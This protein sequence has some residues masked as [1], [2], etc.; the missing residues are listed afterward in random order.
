MNRLK[1]PILFIFCKTIALTFGWA[2]V[3]IQFL[4]PNLKKIIKSYLKDTPASLGK[5][6]L[7]ELET[8]VAENAQI[9]SLRGMESLTGLHALALASNLIDDLGPL[10]SLK[11]LKTL[12]L[13]RNL[14]KKTSI[15]I[16][17]KDLET[18]NLSDNALQYGFLCSFEKL[19]ELDISNNQIQ[20]LNGS[21]KNQKFLKRLNVS[22]NPLSS[23]PNDFECPSLEELDISETQIHSLV[24]LSGLKN[25]RHLY[26]NNCPLLMSL[27]PL[28]YETDGGIACLLPHLESL[29]ISER[30]L[31]VPSKKVLDRIR[32]GE[33]DRPLVLNG[34]IFSGK[35]STTPVVREEKPHVLLMAPAKLSI[36]SSETK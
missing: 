10:A 11:K 20:Q 25:L 27:K 1:L 2:K 7:N 18:L 26:A 34:K 14:I 29:E 30:Y 15:L 36:D 5:E 6:A 3:E 24:E 13:H 23:L 31:D 35:Q 8:L 19:R 33:F 21:F 4:D 32:N 28:F 12:D 22:T 16:Q 9:A 17:L